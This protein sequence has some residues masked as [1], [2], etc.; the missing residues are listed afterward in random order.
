MK[1]EC[2]QVRRARG[3]SRDDWACGRGQGCA[4]RLGIAETAARAPDHH[5][6]YGAEG[7]HRSVS[8][9]PAAGKTTLVRGWDQLIIACSVMAVSRLPW[10]NPR[11][12][13]PRSKR[14]RGRITPAPCGVRP[15][16]VAAKQTTSGTP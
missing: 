10:L 5:R 12:P 14:P 13:P 11:V 3:A 9:V 2:R 8:F 15:P 7:H 6:V 4:A 1:H 16:L